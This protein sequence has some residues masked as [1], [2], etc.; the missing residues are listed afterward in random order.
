MALA[1]VVAVVAGGLAPLQAQVDVNISIGTP[2]PPVRYEVVPP[3]RAGYVW[4]P[5][6]WNWNGHQHV[7]AGGH[8][9]R[10]RPGYVY[11]PPRWVR[12]G[13]RWRFERDRWNRGPKGM[14]PGQ[15][16]KYYRHDGDYDRGRGRGHRD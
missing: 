12:D 11:A 6:Y 15:A 2:P 3:P 1:G 8:W 7:W 9:V 13:D 10:A 14:P 4:V 16:K 5:G